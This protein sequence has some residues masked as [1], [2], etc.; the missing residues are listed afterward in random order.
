M[1]KALLLI[2]V[3]PLLVSCVSTSDA[4]NLGNNRYQIS[5]TNFW[6]WS[7]AGQQADALSAANNYCAKFGKQARVISME[8]RD[9]VAYRSVASGSVTFECVSANEEAEP[10]EL[11][12]GTFLLSGESSGYQGIKARYELMK[13][14]SAFCAK[15]NAKLLPLEGTRETG[16]NMTSRTG[17]ASTKNS[18]NSALQ[19]TSADLLFKCIS[20]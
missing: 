5:S 3:F 13:Q 7:G 19:A 15:R 14:A 6:A 18:A 11:A 9:A 1:K 4:I 12:G 10:I 17:Q 16:I 8:A 2:P 20:Q